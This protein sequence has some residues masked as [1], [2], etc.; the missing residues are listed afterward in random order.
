M[1][2]KIS[3]H[4]LTVIKL[5]VNINYI[6]LTQNKYCILQ[7]KN[8]QYSFLRS[9]GYCARGVGN[10]HSLPHIAAGQRPCTFKSILNRK[11]NKFEPKQKLHGSITIIK[12]Y[13]G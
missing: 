1:R 11:R 8:P 6:S 13:Y 10:A 7:Q 5:A 3:Q 4:F 9:L 12:C 2:N